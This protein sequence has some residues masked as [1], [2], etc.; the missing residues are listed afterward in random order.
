MAHISIWEIPFRSQSGRKLVKI[1]ATV[2]F[3]FF[4]ILGATFIVV[5]R[6][7][8]SPSPSLE[9]VGSFQDV[10]APGSS[11]NYTLT[12]NESYGNLLFYAKGGDNNSNDTFDVTFPASQNSPWPSIQGELWFLTGP[13]NPGQYNIT[14][15]ANSNAATV[16]SFQVALYRVPEAPVSFS[17]DFLLSSSYSS[18][19][20]LF[21]VTSDGVYSLN[22]TALAGDFEIT[23]DG[24]TL[25]VVTNAN[26]TSQQ[27]TAGTHE[28]DIAADPLGRSPAHDEWNVQVGPSTGP[29]GATSSTSSTSSLSS[30]VIQ[31]STTQSLT[32][33]MT[34]TQ[35]SLTQTQTATPSF[36]QTATQGQ[37]TQTPALSLGSAGSVLLYAVIG[38]VVVVAVVLVSVGVFLA[39]RSRGPR[40]IAMP[41]YGAT[42]FCQ[43]CGSPLTGFERFCDRCG[44]PQ[45]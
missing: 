23:L 16:I 13:V 39:F 29:S 10:L 26:A 44:A 30:T 7:I 34:S 8:A 35:P 14:V 5:G 12:L 9:A 43:S 33:T 21:N 32:Q 15:A 38:T 45:T 25:G 28:L 41:T 3:L 22:M 36:T 42:K 1:V 19:S 17:G 37:T 6:A 40:R 20:V 4:V 27:L 31:P 2:L 18:S 11:K 24:N